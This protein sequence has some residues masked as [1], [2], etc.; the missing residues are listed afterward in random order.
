MRLTALA[1]CLLAFGIPLAQAETLGVVSPQKGSWE[2]SAADFGQRLGYFKDVGLDLNILYIN[3]GGESQQAVISGSAEIGLGTGILALLGAL[4]KGAPVK[5]ISNSYIGASDAFWYVRADSPLHSMK[6]TAGKTVGFSTPGSS[7]NLN[8][9]AVLSALGVQG[10][11]PTPTGNPTA[12]MTQ[13]MSGQIDVGYSVTPYALQEI[14]AGQL[15]LIGRADEAPDLAK[16]S[17][18]VIFANSQYLAAHRDTVVR[19]MKALRRTLDWMYTYDPRVMQWYAEG[20]GVPVDVA[21]KSRD[22]FDPQSAS[23]LG[24]PKGLDI[25]MRQAIEFKYLKA[26]LSDAQLASYVDVIDGK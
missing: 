14:D 16:E 7:S 3:G 5:I 25:S 15:R 22:A 17:I 23:A 12:T 1:S 9:L 11:K 20:A 24:P 13:V 10:A 26:P 21:R 18:R 2:N 6:E 4:S 8:L 19:F